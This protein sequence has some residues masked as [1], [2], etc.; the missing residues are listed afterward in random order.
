MQSKEG[1]KPRDETYSSILQY[2]S[3]NCEEEGLLLVK[4]Q[5]WREFY[6]GS[7]FFSSLKALFTNSNC[8]VLPTDLG[9]I[10]AIIECTEKSTTNKSEWS[11]SR[12]ASFMTFMSS[13]DIRYYICVNTERCP[14]TGLVEK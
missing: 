5:V 14:L 6:G 4:E 10:F 7:F 9:P 8:E 11:G 3:R 2:S 12:E 13:G 1:N